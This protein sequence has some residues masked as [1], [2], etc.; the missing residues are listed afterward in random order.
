MK[1]FKDLEFK[2]HNNCKGGIQA[3]MEFPNGYGIS[4][5]QGK[6]FYCNDNTYEVAVLKN[7]N[8]CYDTD[9]T[10]DVLGYQTEEDITRIMKKLQTGDFKVQT[11]Q[12]VEFKNYNY[13]VSN[14]LNKRIEVETLDELFDTISTFENEEYPIRLQKCLDDTVIKEILLK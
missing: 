4:V 1:T 2:P 5:I 3:I 14:N 11:E 12:Y 8:L 7:G 9:I 6:Y 10:D 13:L